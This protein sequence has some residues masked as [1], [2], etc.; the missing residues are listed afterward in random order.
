M[1]N[2]VRAQISTLSKDAG[3]IDVLM[4]LCDF[5]GDRAF[6]VVD[7]LEPNL[8]DVGLA[9]KSNHSVSGS[10]QPF[11]SAGAYDT[12]TFEDLRSLVGRH[13]ELEHQG[14]GNPR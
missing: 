4:R 12:V 7:H 13:L 5:W 3:L 11:K 9:Q 14:K 1:I 6:T 2:T 8:H 10:E